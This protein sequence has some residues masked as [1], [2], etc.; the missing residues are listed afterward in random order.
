M[1]W[2]TFAFWVGAILVIV[3]VTVFYQPAAASTGSL[4]VWTR[5]RV[6][7]M[8]IDNLT[9]ERVGPA[10]PNELIT[11]SPGCFAQLETPCWVVVEDRLYE[12]ELTA[13]RNKV[14]QTRLPIE[15]GTRWAAAPVSWSPDG[16][17]LAYSLIQEQT[18]QAQLRVYNA[19][20]GQIKIRAPNVDPSVSVAW[21][22]GCAAGLQASDCELGYKKMPS[23]PEV[24]PVLIGFTPAT[25]EQRQ[26]IIS[27]EPIYE[28]R[29]SPDGMLLYSRPKRH[30]VSAQDHTPAYHIP[31]GSS[32]ANMSPHA[33]YIVYYQPFTLEGCQSEDSE[34][35]CLHLGVWLAPANDAGDDRSLIY[36]VDVSAATQERGLNFI[37][38]WSPTGDVFVFFQEGRLIHYSLTRQEATIWYKAVAGKLRSV[39]VFSP[40]EEAV[41]FIDNQGQGRSEYRLVVVNPKLQP[42]E[43]IIDTEHGFRVLA[44]LPN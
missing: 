34:E 26:W 27:T 20:T 15:E 9:L 16:L 14:T 7:I 41:A 1:K 2:T 5:N 19:A 29:W 44:W 18:N 21:T 28:L 38:V 13:G 36:N 11:P 33:D 6:Y 22:T 42:V 32:L 3:L 23:L 43:H 4:L 8:D 25:G 37:P 31:P 10:A 24:V 40:N 17:H 12:I 39:P 30:F 35:R